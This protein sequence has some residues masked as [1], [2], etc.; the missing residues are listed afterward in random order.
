M[1]V[2]REVKACMLVLFFFYSSGASAYDGVNPE[3]TVVEFLDRKP[4]R[5]A[6]DAIERGDETAVQEAL[7]DGLNVSAAI[8]LSIPDY[9]GTC[10]FSLLD[11]A[12][13]E[14]QADIV[15]ML[16][17]QGA[18]PNGCCPGGYA[19][20]FAQRRKWYNVVE[21]LV[22]H[23]ASTNSKMFKVYGTSFE[24]GLTPLLLHV[25]KWFKE[26]TLDCE[27]DI[28]KINN[29]EFLIN[30]GADMSSTLGGDPLLGIAMQARKDYTVGLFL[31]HGV[32]LNDLLPDGGNTL[33]WMA[34]N[35]N[36]ACAKFTP[37]IRPS[38]IQTLGIYLIAT[39]T[40]GYA[41]SFARVV[42][43]F[44]EYSLDMDLC[45]NSH[46]EYWNII[47]SYI[48]FGGHNMIALAEQDEELKQILGIGRELM[49]Q[50]PKDF[51]GRP[52]CCHFDVMKLEPALQQISKRL[53]DKNQT[54]NIYNDVIDVEQ[55]DS[56]GNTALYYAV[57]HGNRAA[58]I[59]LLKLG[60]DV[61][62]AGEFDLTPL[63]LAFQNWDMWQVMALISAGM[64]CE[65]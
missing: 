52:I 50:H 28:D 2:L 25:N 5:S 22:N 59:M 36:W 10:Y 48:K 4:Y 12:V 16:L 57:K 45:R 60:A 51:K 64:Q 34:K 56:A 35:I 38:S 63:Q 29:I 30:N 32:R 62:H 3:C 42:T 33:H 20:L 21:I 31:R 41:A 40:Y 18:S 15:T 43:K 1:M 11:F 39:V 54:A 27:I 58:T 44:Y 14:N 65:L 7:R 6:F 24:E 53:S 26:L 47:Y 13:T 55:E 19:F 23:G 37:L 46:W 17:E 9:R 49:K 8:R 61:Y